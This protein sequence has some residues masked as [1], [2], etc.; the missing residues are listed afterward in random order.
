MFRKTTSAVHIQH[1]LYTL[2]S[3]TV[4]NEIGQKAQKELY[5]EQRIENKLKEL[6]K[7]YKRR[8]EYSN[9]LE[10]SECCRGFWL[11]CA[12]ETLDQIELLKEIK[13]E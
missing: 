6:E 7:R 5:M 10:L 3:Y 11:R 2:K 12:I 8:I 4:Y 13:G 9:R 1:R